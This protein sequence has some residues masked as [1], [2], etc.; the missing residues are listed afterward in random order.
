M[1]P[2]DRQASRRQIIGSI[3]KL[4]GA[5]ILIVWGA[6]NLFKLIL[7]LY[8][9]SVK[10]SGGQAALSA[11]VVVALSLALVGWGAWLLRQL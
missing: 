1:T 2:S 7:D 6:T 4:L 11:L 9:T 8:Y 3:S 5:T 10:G